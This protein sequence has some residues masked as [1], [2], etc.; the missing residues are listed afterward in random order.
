MLSTLRSFSPL[1]NACHNIINFNIIYKTIIMAYDEISR[2][3]FT[4][5]LRMRSPKH[6]SR[7]C[8]VIWRCELSIHVCSLQLMQTETTVYYMHRMWL[9]TVMS[10]AVISDNVALH[11]SK[12]MQVNYTGNTAYRS[13]VKSIDSDA[14]L[15]LFEAWTFDTFLYSWAKFVTSKS[16]IFL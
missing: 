8:Y 11:S 16:K 10:A 4:I 14:S 1:F 13:H 7:V 6:P 9:C 12:Q 3:S 2:S 15:Y 5:I